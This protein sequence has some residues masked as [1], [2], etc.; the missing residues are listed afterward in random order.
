M[1]L[2]ELEALAAKWTSL[3]PTGPADLPDREDQVGQVDPAGSAGRRRAIL[4]DKGRNAGTSIGKS[5][6]LNL[7]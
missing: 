4:A 7:T 3:R 1:T 5:K 6:S 2:E